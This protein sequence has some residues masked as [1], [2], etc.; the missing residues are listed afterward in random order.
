MQNVC[1]IEELSVRVGELAEDA[2]GILALIDVAQLPVSLVPGLLKQFMALEKRAAAG[3]VLITARAV[4]A[5]RWKREGY[6]SP[7][8]W[9]AATQGCSTGRAGDDLATSRRLEELEDT[10]DALKQGRLSP[11][12]AGAVSDA[13]VVNPAAEKDLLDQAERDSLK[14]LRDEAAR[15][16]A[17]AEDLEAKRKR[18]HNARRAR[19]WIG[20][21]GA[22][23]FQ[24]TGPI[25]L[26]SRFQQ[27]WERFTN[28]HFHHHRSTGNHQSHDN[29]AF[30]AFLALTGT[31]TPTTPPSPTTPPGPRSASPIR[32]ED[33]CSRNGGASA[34]AVPTTQRSGSADGRTSAGQG[35]PSDGRSTPAGHDTTNHGDSRGASNSNEAPCG[36]TGDSLQPVRHPPASL[37]DPPH[38]NKPP[39]TA[40]PPGTA[41]PPGTAGPPGTAHP[42]LGGCPPPEPEQESDELPPD[43]EPIAPKQ[44]ARENLRHLAILRVDLSALIAGD[45]NPGETCEIAGLGPIAV[46]AAREL[47]PDSIL[48]LVI[49]RGTDVINVTH[50]G[51]GP[52]TAQ[53]VALLWSQPR[54]SVQGCNRHQHT[55][56]DHRTPWATQRE[57][58]LNNIDGLCHYHHQQKTLH[59]WALEPGTGPRQF[60]PPEHPNHPGCTTA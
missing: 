28:A 15:R 10:T 29:N 40:E 52:T 3:R 39:G 37:F 30:D 54:C 47:L 31:T 46:S 53:Q 1:S 55:Q 56:W 6:K 33:N 25:E 11:D 27:Q 7:A 43:V 49:T 57:T 36:F 9:L 21:D 58:H 13:A 20:R 16:K 2:A 23:N 42:L 60:L 51:R 50:L 8:E 34:S 44:P 19:V 26:G 4:K 14:N 41:K 5:E 38:T 22:W 18:I 24:A 32:G 45:T 17:E 35:D 48:K 12:Q 59:G